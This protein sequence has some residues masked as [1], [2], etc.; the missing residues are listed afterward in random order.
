MLACKQYEE[1]LLSGTW[2]GSS[3]L[4]ANQPLDIEPSNIKLI[5]EPSGSYRYESTLNYQ[6]AG[7][8]FLDQQYLYTM[9]TINQASTEK[10]VEIM[11]L[12][13][14][15]LH[16]RMNEAGKERLLKMAREM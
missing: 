14:D 8:Y 9:D 1:D 5:L 11:L 2:R 15:S 10:A 12:T 7:T 16:L 3:I 4:E 6:E 13:Q